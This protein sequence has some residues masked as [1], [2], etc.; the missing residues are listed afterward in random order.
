MTELLART[1]KFHVRHDQEN[2]DVIH[3]NI[4]G[5]G[6][7]TINRTGEGVIVDVYGGMGDG[8][9]LASI[10]LMDDDFEESEESYCDKLMELIT[11]I[12]PSQEVSDSHFCYSAYSDKIDLVA[13]VESWFADGCF[14]TDELTGLEGINDIHL[15]DQLTPSKPHIHIV[16]DIHAKLKE[17]GHKYFKSGTRKVFTLGGELGNYHLAL[18]S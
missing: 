11:D 14:D 2:K 15:A 1:E 8:D 7:V 4:L 12:D 10:S 17:T 5:L 3:V 9:S 13:A 16:D 6:F 18:L